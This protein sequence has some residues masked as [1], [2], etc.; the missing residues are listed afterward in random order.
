MTYIAV[1]GLCDMLRKSNTSV[2]ITKSLHVPIM[3]QK[4]QTRKTLIRAQQSVRDARPS[5]APSPSAHV[6]LTLQQSNGELVGH[7]VSH[8][9]GHVRVQEPRRQPLQHRAAR[10]SAETA[11]TR[12]ARDG[13]N[14][15]IRLLNIDL[16]MQNFLRRSLPYP[17]ALLHTENWQSLLTQQ[18]LSPTHTK[19]ISMVARSVL[20]NSPV[21]LVQNSLPYEHSLISCSGTEHV[22]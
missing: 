22:Y 20:N 5:G 12:G 1:Q 17:S 2:D 3:S 8:V 10:H 4:R 11:A 14:C 15:L 13:T 19:F 16:L 21:L 18:I 6:P 9:L 7:H